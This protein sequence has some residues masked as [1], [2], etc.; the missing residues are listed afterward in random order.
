MINVN[1]IL[2]EFVNQLR[3]IASEADERGLSVWFDDFKEEFP[4]LHAHLVKSR[5]MPNASLALGYLIAQE[6]SLAAVKF[7][8]NHMRM[9]QFVHTWMNQRFGQSEPA[10][11][12][13][14]RRR[15]RPRK[16]RK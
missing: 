2:L 10:P 9:V 12:P 3:E 15:L 14:P 16:S 13:P 5:E 8:P 1:P 6:P 7:I 4:N 11:A